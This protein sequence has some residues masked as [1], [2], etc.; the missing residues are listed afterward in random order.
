MELNESEVLVAS[1]KISGPLTLF[2]VYQLYVHH[3][4]KKAL[5]FAS[6]SGNSHTENEG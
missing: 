6:I 4:L 1:R 2:Y 5:E 3:S